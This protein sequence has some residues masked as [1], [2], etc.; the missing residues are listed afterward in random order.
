MLLDSNIVIYASRS[1]STN[2]RQFIRIH[3]LAASI[4]SYIE[5]FGYHNLVKEERLVLEELFRDIELLRLTDEIVDISIELRQ[6][7]R[8][9]LGDAIIA[10]TALAHNHTLLTHNTRDFQ[11]IEGLDLQDPLE[12][13]EQLNT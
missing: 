4:V 9:G 12:E 7:R 8:M 2:L 13:Q 11:W 5:A 10:A 6:Q 3:A 1:D